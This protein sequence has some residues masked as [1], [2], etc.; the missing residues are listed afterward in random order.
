MKSG[1]ESYTVI[2]MLETLA[3]HRGDIRI[4]TFFC[5]MDINEI[6]GKLLINFEL[7]QKKHSLK[8]DAFYKP[9]IEYV[10]LNRL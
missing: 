10:E 2:F 5:I 4:D 8:G 3:Q 1:M 6:L 9:F 7:F